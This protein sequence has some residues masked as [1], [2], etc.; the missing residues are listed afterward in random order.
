MCNSQTLQ[1]RSRSGTEFSELV[2]SPGVCWRVGGICLVMKLD[3]NSVDT[4]TVRTAGSGLLTCHYMASRSACDTVS[5]ITITRSTSFQDHKFTPLCNTYSDTIFWTLVQLQ[6]I[7]IFQQ[8]NAKA[9]TK[10]HFHDSC[11]YG[12]LKPSIDYNKLNK[13][14]WIPSNGKL[15][16]LLQL[17]CLQ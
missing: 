7:S 6:N 3:F 13:N 2:F 16:Q 1:N 5:A 14:K 15:Q 10:N 11:K 12:E 17:P 4:C 9:N 8:N